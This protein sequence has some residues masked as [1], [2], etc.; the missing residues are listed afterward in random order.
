MTEAVLGGNDIFAKQLL[1]GS[2]QWLSRIDANIAINTLGY[3]GIAGADVNG[4]GLEDVYVCQGTGL[5]NRLFIQN[6]DGTA[7]DRAAVAGVDWIEQSSGVLLID[8]NNDGAPDL[9]VAAGT[10]LQQC[11]SHLQ[12][13]S[14][15]YQADTVQ[16]DP[17][18][19]RR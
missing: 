9:I 5:P 16:K 2:N 7:T 4:D 10:D 12:D 14:D 6:S 13:F 18:F 17:L 3:Q 19:L 11:L 15:S 1:P 8:L